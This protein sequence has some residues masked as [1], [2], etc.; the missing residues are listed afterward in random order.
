MRATKGPPSSPEMT[1][2]WKA[3]KGCASARMKEMRQPDRQMD[4][5]TGKQATYEEDS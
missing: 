3:G 5:L 2:R 4:R 1:R